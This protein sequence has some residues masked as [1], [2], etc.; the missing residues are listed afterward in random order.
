MLVIPDHIKGLIFDLDGTLV[1]TMPLHL[2][3]WVAV[4]EFF[5]VP[6]TEELINQHLG[7]ST[8][9]LVNRFNN[10][11]GWGLDPKSVRK[12]KSEF[13]DRFKGEVGKIKPI[14][15]I[16]TIALDQKGKMPMC[17]ATGSSR[18][19]AIRSLEDIGAADWW[20]KVVT[21]SD[22]IPGKPNPEI[23]QVCAEAMS[24]RP[25]ECMV[26]E[27]GPSGIEAA[28]NAGMLVVDVTKRK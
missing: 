26:F 21:G 16:Y 11:F 1:D 7:T 13:Y 3:S 20:V 12:K 6:I 2:K 14:E 15:E 10:D 23:F 28:T 27:D 25:E 9:A 8:I 17:I 24:L 4:G 19:N 22:D 18:G 5:N